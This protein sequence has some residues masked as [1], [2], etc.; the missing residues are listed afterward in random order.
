MASY[1]K[2]IDGNHLLEIGLEGF[3]GSSTPDKIKIN[4]NSYQFGTDFIANNQIPAIDFVTVHS[5]PDQW[6]KNAPGSAQL[7]FLKQWV[8]QHIADSQ[9]ILRKPVIFAEFGKS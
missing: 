3:Y 7:T 1:L 4:P 2:S 6:L 9:N 8:D 5:Y